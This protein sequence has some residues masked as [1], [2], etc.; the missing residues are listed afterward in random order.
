MVN[1]FK[2]GLTANEASLIATNLERFSSL[3][4][5]KRTLQC[6]EESVRYAEGELTNPYNDEGVSSMGWDD[7]NSHDEDYKNLDL[8]EQIYEAL[9]DEVGIACEWHDHLSGE[10]ELY[11]SDIIPLPRNDTHLEV[12]Q[13]SRMAP[14]DEYSFCP[15]PTQ[16]TITKVSL[17]KWFYTHLP[18]KA[19]IFDPTESYKTIET[20]YS[21]DKNLTDDILNIVAKAT[22]SQFN[23]SKKV[24]ETIVWQD[25]YKLTEKAL[26]LFPS[27]QQSRP[28]PNN[29]PKSHIDEW[30]METL[31]ATK[32]E[33]ETIKKIIIE[34]FNL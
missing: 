10:V 20:G 28:K 18:D 4:D 19:S 9:L 6:E 30:L 7:I 17:A 13:I 27:W 24:T 15:I 2:R 25:L 33:A 11:L 31:K 14:D 1:K 26:E 22:D 5:A 29:V 32:R 34:V 23:F 12:F 16:T 21:T 8:A 3:L